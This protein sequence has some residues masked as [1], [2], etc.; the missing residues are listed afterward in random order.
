MTS[1]RRFLL[2]I[3]TTVVAVVVGFSVVPGASATTASGDP[4][5]VATPHP[6]TP[7]ASRPGESGTHIITGAPPVTS[8]HTDN[9]VSPQVVPPSF[10]G[11]VTT[12]NGTPL[13]A[14]HMAAVEF[15][16]T[17]GDFVTTY[18]TTTDAQGAYTFTN[19]PVDVYLIQAHDATQQYA[20]M[21]YNNE[22]PYYQPDFIYFQG[23]SMYYLDFYLPVAAHI[24]G[25]VQGPSAADFAAGD[26]KAEVEVLD[27]ST[28]SPVWFETGDFWPVASDGTFDVGD[29]PPDDYRLLFS[30][31]SDS[32]YPTV[33]TSTVT[34][35]EGQ[36]FHVG[37]VSLTKT[38]NG[39]LRSLAPARILDT[40]S[41]IGAPTGAVAPNSFVAVQVAGQGGVPASGVSAVVLNV[42]VAGSTG[43]GFVTAYA[44]GT[45][46]P[47]ASNLNFVPGQIV[48]NLVVVPVSQVNGKVDLYN[49]SFGS[50]QLVA[51]VAGYYVSGTP[52][53]PGAFGS[54]AP[55]RLL[56]TRSGVGAPTGAVASNGVVAL[57][58][59]GQGGVPAGATA[60]VLN[61]TVAGSSAEGFVTAY[62]DGSARPTAS[63]LNFVPG[64]VV[65]NLVVV[66][67]SASGKVDLYN[68]SSGATQ[69]V[70]DVAGYYLPGIP[71]GAGAFGS[72]PPYRLLDTRSGIGAPQGPVAP[73]GVVQLHVLG[74]GGVPASGVSAVVLNV[75]VAGSTGSGFVTAYAHEADRPT[76]SNLNFVPGQI[77]PNLVVVPVDADGYVDLYNG[78]AG[79]T[80]LVADVA[81][82]FGV[83]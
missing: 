17:S 51:D 53:A 57:Q 59:T 62:A 40:R 49:G 33:S 63:N 5:T 66:P 31:S 61:V 67:L 24:Q 22:S 48:P 81:G 2:A 78:S 1:T 73:H 30:D 8:S 46:R 9:T 20:T 50:T 68:G 74:Q 52:T 12:I 64:Q 77:V 35:G 75:T 3:V 38:I 54:L 32:L 76:A 65:P 11:H 4:V 15:D 79:S 29:L 21:D 27:Y 18:T 25:T 47:T 36:T 82:W 23:G 10:T 72:L 7:A 26:V 43:A 39:G 45:T 80:Q 56:D 34:L 37:T 42:T 41:G 71:S 70:A 6:A 28:G 19:L 60:A 83:G 69:L 55:Y 58:V 14:I 16:A 44:D 13:A